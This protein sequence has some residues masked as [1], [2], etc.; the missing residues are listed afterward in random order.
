MTR[1]R[2]DTGPGDR[3]RCMFCLESVPEVE[4]PGHVLH[5]HRIS[6]LYLDG[7]EDG[8]GPCQESRYV[9]TGEEEI[10][11]CDDD[12]Q[13]DEDLYTASAVNSIA[14]DFQPDCNTA[15]VRPSDED[16]DDEE[17]DFELDCQCSFCLHADMEHDVTSATDYS[18]LDLRDTQ[19]DKTPSIPTELP[20]QESLQPTPKKVTFANIT[21]YYPVKK[22]G[23]LDRLKIRGGKNVKSQILGPNTSLRYLKHW[24]SS[25]KPPA[26]DPLELIKRTKR[27]KSCDIDVKS[28]A[29]LRSIGV[30]V[31]WH[32]PKDGCKF[33]GQNILTVRKHFSTHFQSK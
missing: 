22:L 18:S 11:V 30:A 17:S 33:T 32:C 5:H 23:W 16:D 15:E 1:V 2:L 9:Q 7:D 28:V 31:V 8:P 12:Q 26:A 4:Y 25:E 10:L 24:G 14:S 19:T 27:N 3:V 29:S 13:N 20:H 6:G 21:N